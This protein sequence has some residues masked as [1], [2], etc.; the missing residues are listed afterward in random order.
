MAQTMD[1][2]SDHGLHATDLG[3]FS[4][5]DQ[6]SVDD[7]SMDPYSDL[8]HDSIN[9]HLNVASSAA[10][11]PSATVALEKNPDEVIETDSTDILSRQAVGSHLGTGY[12][13]LSSG[14]F[15]VFQED[16]SSPL[17]DLARSTWV[18]PPNG[19]AG[20]SIDILD[21]IW[22]IHLA[23]IGFKL[24]QVMVLEHLQYLSK[25]LVPNYEMS[26]STQP[27]HTLSIVLM[28]NEMFRLRRADPWSVFA[29]DLSKFELLFLQVQHLLLSTDYDLG[30]DE[31]RFLLIF[32][33]H[34]FE[35]LEI[36]FVRSE[37]LKITGIG[38]W[39]E[40]MSREIC[41]QHVAEA[42]ER[43]ALWERSEKRYQTAKQSIKE[44]L[45]FNRSFLSKLIWGFLDILADIPK[46][47]S[48]PHGAVAYCERFVE[49]L[50]C[51]DFQLPTRRHVHILLFD[52]LVVTS[53]LN[54]T[55]YALSFKVKKIATSTLATIDSWVFHE[56]TPGPIFKRLVDRLEY[57]ST[58]P[59]DDV[60][61][62]ALSARD[63]LDKHYACIH[64]VQKICF[65]LFNDSLGEFSL[66]SISNMSCE[67]IKSHFKPLSDAT[68]QE[69]CK[70]VGIRTTLPL[71]RADAMVHSRSFLIDMICQLLT[72][73]KLR[74]DTIHMESVY[75]TENTLFDE[76]VCP[77]NNLFSNTHCS[78]V[79]K[80]TLQYL[81]MQDYALRQLDLHKIYFFMQLRDYIEDAIMRLSPTYLK[82]T[83]SSKGS[84]IF[85][86]F[87]QIALP[88]VQF[89]ISEV[90]HPMLTESKPAFVKGD[91]VYSVGKLA[92]NVRNEWDMIR[93]GD[94]L[95]LLNVQMQP[96]ANEDGFD[97]IVTDLNIGESGALFMKR[98][99]IVSVRGC[100]V[101]ELLGENG[102]P[103][104]DFISAQTTRIHEDKPRVWRNQR[105][106]SV[107]F[108]TNQY[109]LDT[110]TGN[111]AKTNVSD[112]FNVVIRLRSELNNFKAVL[113]ALRDAAHCSDIV[114]EWFHDLVLGYGDRK[115]A[116]YS[117]LEFSDC[118]VYVGKTFE[119]LAHLQE[120]FPNWK[121]SAAYG[122]SKTDGNDILAPPFVLTLPQALFVASESRDPLPLSELKIGSKRS[123]DAMEDSSLQTNDSVTVKVE[124]VG[125]PMDSI[126]DSTDNFAKAKSL[127]FTREQSDA[128]ISGSI[129][130]LTLISGV[131]GSG[132]TSIAAQI[133]SN[134]VNGCPS[135]R[136]LV[137]APTQRQLVRLLGN[138][139][140][141]GVNERYVISLS[142]GFG[143]LRAD[144][145]EALGKL[146]RINHLLSRRKHLLTRVDQL[147]KS[148]GV[149]GEHGSSCETA[150]YFYS[151]HVNSL[152]T[153]YLEDS[154]RQSSLASI[155]KNFPF[156]HF[157][158][159]V[160]DRQ[161]IS[162]LFSANSLESAVS[163]A[164]M[165][166]QHIQDIF[167]ELAETQALEL[168]RSRKD[169]ADYIISKQ[170]RVIGITA[171]D[172]SLKRRELARLGFHFQNFIVDDAHQ[173]FE[174]DT[175][176]SLLLNR[177]TTW[178][179]PK[180]DQDMLDGLKRIVMTG[181]AVS[182]PRYISSNALKYY[183]NFDQSLFSRLIK[184]GVPTL[185]LNV[186]RRLRPSIACFSRV[187]YPL[188]RC[189]PTDQLD[190]QMKL[191]NPGFVYDAQF[192]NVDQ[193]L[194]Q[195]ET[196]PRKDFF[197]NLGEAEYLVAVF[198]YMR[199]IGYPAG[200]IAILT[201]YKGQKELIRDVLEQRC[202]WNPVFGT[203]QHIKTIDE[204]RGNVADYV[205][206]SLVRTRTAGVMDDQIKM[207]SLLSSA[208]LGLYVFGR[209]S[210]YISEKGLFTELAKRPTSLYLYLDE[211]YSQGFSREL[212]NSSFEIGADGDLPETLKNPSIVCMSN[213]EHMGQ[214]VHQ[215]AQEQLSWLQQQVISQPSGHGARNGRD[216]NRQDH[217]NGK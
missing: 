207:A 188:M 50:I 167:N 25:Y 89:Q 33:T 145:D 120:S 213:V 130:G 11:V 104:D 65:T 133:V 118:P 90:G 192:I 205:L 55:L 5:I 1:D 210:T 147:A 46:S 112:T 38:I 17:A 16:L 4:V 45:L 158:T 181:N 173:M 86:G 216:W 83:M 15:F 107:L 141:F 135:D 43:Q 160:K 47:G 212:D 159:S 178:Q 88:I 19:V 61:G 198:Q 30:F 143:E 78:P 51:L 103:V 58:F 165:L 177:H 44:K 97:P 115:S 138:L 153:Q 27:V 100:E 189:V 200:K 215:M 80:L 144:S 137:V 108:D 93:P 32:L 14:L 136:T 180:N 197:Q 170:A 113:D 150:N 217:R 154:S 175:L 123:S 3:F 134:I 202:S 101:C 142:H 28:I 68:L 20:F 26:A 162:L 18:D 128:I 37:C 121:F 56:Y 140:Q 156:T 96:T 39:H 13:C 211:K 77:A 24:R 111:K 151:F 62:A 81:T 57:Y 148:I 201:P 129:K 214:Y 85:K 31:R 208:R 199:L 102:K 35:S 73:P 23:P 127:K 176:V 99:G 84:T 166:Y 155:T 36:P 114:P 161:R 34:C 21:T 139:I 40:L 87:S 116:H 67:E 22:K 131:P 117:Q 122:S 72:K 29:E 194:G 203:P 163:A 206:V 54:S 187:F 179:T 174:M 149:P 195:H 42:P 105:S 6:N 10:T 98:Y 146:G 48:A 169:R 184:L 185:T 66:L 82:D 186:Q 95:I 125:T 75:P 164:T 63:V 191:A 94:H 49:F 152:W 110:L 157:F 76:S 60:T 209:I 182:L 91:L 119:S 9:H 7:H 53:C 124:S 109:L 183:S 70:R 12:E 52:H 204:F 92:H 172:I 71:T 69:F 171:T 74:S 2:M 59:I 190:L 41:E 196:E 106:I 79:P 193:F 132:K 8:E 126:L 64:K 168:L